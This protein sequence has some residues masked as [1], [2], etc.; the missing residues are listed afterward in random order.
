MS[1]RED[2]YNSFNAE[3]L[4]KDGMKRLREVCEPYGIEAF[5]FVLAAL[6]YTQGLLPARRH[7]TGREL[8]DGILAY[9]KKEFGPMAL[10]V[11]EHWGIVSTEDFGRIVF[12]MVEAGILAK[13][14]Q[15]SLADFK[16]VY[17]LKKVF[18]PR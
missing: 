2:V 9:G 5:Q 10:S 6:E 1:A 8:L 18:E 15:D 14:Q 13:T 16:D 7:V 17:D 11:F 3:N 12:A 4:F